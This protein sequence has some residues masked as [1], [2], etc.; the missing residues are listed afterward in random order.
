[1][2][3]FG[4]NISWISSLGLLLGSDVPVVS[5]VRR[6]F[7][8]MLHWLWG[9]LVLEVAEMH[10]R[11]GGCPGGK[12]WRDLLLVSCFE[13]TKEEAMSYVVWLES[14]DGDWRDE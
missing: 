2:T 1:M 6:I 13:L 3:D 5:F 8:G 7:D 14:I 11:L 10:W 12:F 4:N 9:W